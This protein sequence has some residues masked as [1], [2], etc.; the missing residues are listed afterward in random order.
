MDFITEKCQLR[1]R[2]VSLYLRNAS[3]MNVGSIFWSK[4]TQRR[5]GMHRQKPENS[6][7]GFMCG[8][9][10]GWVKEPSFTASLGS[11][12]GVSE[13]QYL[14]RVSVLVRVYPL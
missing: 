4:S 7:P 3:S 9:S 5:W 13:R 6:N 8:V 10:L 12:N 14:F 1:L 11:S 2:N